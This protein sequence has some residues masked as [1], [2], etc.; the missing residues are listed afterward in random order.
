MS[1][2]YSAH[3]RAASIIRRRMRAGIHTCTHASRRALTHRLR[4]DASDDGE[5]A[6][7]SEE[8]CAAGTACDALGKGHVYHRHARFFAYAH[9][10]FLSLSYCQ[11]L[12][13]F[14]N[15]FADVFVSVTVKR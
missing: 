14:V 13:F 3:T 2:G 5:G 9:E 1:H 10:V 11:T 15:T 8:N 7:L 6:A 12:T 4:N